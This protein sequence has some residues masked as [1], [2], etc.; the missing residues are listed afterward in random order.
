MSIG[1]GAVKFSAVRPP[2]LDEKE[3]V[4]HVD[5]VVERPQRVG[6]MMSMDTR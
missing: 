5:A 4:A 6:V 2:R 3:A 1:S